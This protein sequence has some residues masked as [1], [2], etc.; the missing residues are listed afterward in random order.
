MTTHL[1]MASATPSSHAH[2]SFVPRQVE[3]HDKVEMTTENQQTR[4][5]LLQDTVF[6]DW[7][8]DASSNDLAD[9]SE[10]QRK[11]PLGIQIWKLYSRT[12]SQ[13]PNQERMD[14]LTW[15]MMSM[16]LKRKEREQARYVARRWGWKGLVVDLSAKWAV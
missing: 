10:M 11:D 1:P 2:S 14:N 5:V 3:V 7:K 12:K 8:D 13:L 9:P 6:A 15:R 16:N 4:Q